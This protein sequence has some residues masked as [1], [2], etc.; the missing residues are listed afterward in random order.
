MAIYLCMFK[1]SSNVTDDRKCLSKHWNNTR[2][3]STVLLTSATKLL[4]CSV[5]IS[6]WGNEVLQKYKNI[7]KPLNHIPYIGV[8]RLPSALPATIKTN[9]NTEKCFC[10]G[11]VSYTALH[12]PSF[13]PSFMHFFFPL[14]LHSCG[15]TKTRSTPDKTEV[16]HIASSLSLLYRLSMCSLC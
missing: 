10:Q 5:I 6:L 2:K 4:E 11:F 14:L 12:H 16:R 1:Q 3:A 13:H 15:G 7:I 9:G 8:F